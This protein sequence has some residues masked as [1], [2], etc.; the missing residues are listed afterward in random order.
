MFNFGDRLRQI[1]EERHLTQKQFAELIGS[2]ERGIRHYELGERKPGL[3][4]IMAILDNVDVSADYLLGSEEVLT[5]EVL[6]QIIVDTLFEHDEKVKAAGGS[7]QFGDKKEAME[8]SALLLRKYH[9]F[10]RA[11]LAKQGIKI[12]F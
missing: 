3:D 6:D 7:S 11:E 5:N 9:N 2:T 8:Y 12:R 4:V 1:R 10:L